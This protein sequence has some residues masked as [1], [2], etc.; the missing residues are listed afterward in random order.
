M[1]KDSNYYETCSQISLFDMSIKKP[2]DYYVSNLLYR[3]S[4]LLYRNLMIV[5]LFGFLCNH[6]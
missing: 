6:M 3:F 5:Y 1:S 2:V 4:I